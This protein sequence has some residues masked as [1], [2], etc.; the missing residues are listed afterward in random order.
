MAH[1]IIT[2][3]YWNAHPEIQ[4]DYKVGDSIEVS[5]TDIP[6]PD[7]QP[8]PIAP[9]KPSSSLLDG[10]GKEFVGKIAATSKELPLPSGKIATISEFKG[11]HVFKAQRYLSE[12]NSKENGAEEM[13]P[14]IISICTLIDGKAIAPEDLNEM[15]GQDVLVL[16]GEF[17][18]ANFS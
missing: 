6:M 2:E 11:K 17:S 10:L 13:L 15:S 8:G 3:D 16:M 7:A 12:S 9:A 18:A 5:D 14:I 4:A 1:L